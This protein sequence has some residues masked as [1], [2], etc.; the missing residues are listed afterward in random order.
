MSVL[1]IQPIPFFA[2]KDKAFW[3]LQFVGWGGA[4]L[5]RTM[6][7]IANSQPLTS[8]VLVLIATITG[9][10]ISLVLSVVYRTLITRRALVTWGLTA[11]ILPFAVGLHAFIDAWVISLYR[12]DSD[13]SFTQLFLGVFY[14]DATLLGAWSALYYAINFYLQV[15]EQNDQ[16]IRLENQATQAQLAML[17]YQ[18]NPHF[19]FNT[20]NSISTLVLL[21]QTEPANAMLSRLSSFLRYTLV[22]K[23]SARV[24]VATEVETLELYLDIELMRF[25]ERLRTTFHIDPETETCL[26]PSLL[27]QPLV[28]NS[29]KYAVTPQES[30]AEIT[31]TTQLV[32]PMLR[33]TVS[34]TGPGLQSPTTDNRLSGMTYDGGE[35]VSTGVGLANIRD[36]LSQAYGEHHRFETIEPIEGGFAVL[37]ELPAERQPTPE[38]MIEQPRQPVFA[39]R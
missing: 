19:L 26:L 25:E 21:K 35:P 27:L 31:I 2:N 28:E 29:I 39:A 20:L 1:P 34:D 32:G 12:T 6:S 30:G 9:F 17:R 18:L 8:L 3:R 24:T 14:L 7:T 22:N 16:M 23:P 33:I 15:E 36:R 13:A 37:I 10:S 11:L 4:M 38:D 5:L